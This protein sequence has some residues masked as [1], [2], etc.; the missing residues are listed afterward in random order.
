VGA[1]EADLGSIVNEAFCR[2]RLLFR[3]CRRAFTERRETLDSLSFRDRRK[4][5]LRE[6]ERFSRRGEGGAAQPG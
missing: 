2:D 5:I 4:G 1:P 6:R 3:A